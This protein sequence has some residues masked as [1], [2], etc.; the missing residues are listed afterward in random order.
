MRDKH[1]QLRV[2]AQEKNKI[3]RE[4]LKRGFQSIGAFLF[5]LIHQAQIGK[6]V[7][8]LSL[9]FYLS[10]CGTMWFWLPDESRARSLEKLA[11]IERERL[12]LE[13]QQSKQNPTNQP[14]N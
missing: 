2:N 5:W 4:A 10:G 11:E 14:V 7:L 1:I 9:S 6:I 3:K 12:E 8:L 13:K